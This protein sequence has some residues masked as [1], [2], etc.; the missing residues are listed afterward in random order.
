MGTGAVVFS[1]AFG[2]FGWYAD[3]YVPLPFWP[4]IAGGGALLGLHFLHLRWQADA[5]KRGER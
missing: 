1:A 2:L 3:A 5:E 4:I